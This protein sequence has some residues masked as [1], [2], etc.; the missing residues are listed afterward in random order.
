MSNSSARASKPDE[1][2]G[3]NPFQRVGGH[4]QSKTVSGL[5]ELAPLIVTILVVLFL[6]ENADGLVR[7]LVRRF[8]TAPEGMEWMTLDF[9][10]IGLV[11]LIVIFYIVGLIVATRPGRAVMRLLSTVIGYI[12]VIKTVFGVTRQATELITSDQN[13]SRVVFVEWPR[14]GM[15]AMGFVTGTVYPPDEEKSLALVYIPTVPNPTSG[16]MALVYEDEIFESDISV[17]EAMKLVF[18]GGI[19]LPETLTLARLPIMERDGH[20]LVG[21][22]KIKPEQWSAERDS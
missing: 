11:A 4:F 20:P 13:F 9:P 15:A 7:P 8:W 12:P 5:L 21:A 2:K 22:Y 6:I 17:E 14:E 19:V 18:S 3:P 16:N 1:E 10:G